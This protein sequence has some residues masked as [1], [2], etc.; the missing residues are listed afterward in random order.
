[1]TFKFITIESC[2]L[3]AGGTKQIEPIKQDRKKAFKKKDENRDGCSEP[4]VLI[5]RLTDRPWVQ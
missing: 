4:G 3:S 1:M 2:N 5:S